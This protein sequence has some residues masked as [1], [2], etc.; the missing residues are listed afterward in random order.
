MNI[1]AIKKKL[2]IGNYIKVEHAPCILAQKPTQNKPTQ[3]K[4]WG[5]G[6]NLHD[7]K[8]EKK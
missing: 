7:N 6:N 8:R 3:N 5:E 2:L 1:N 4:R